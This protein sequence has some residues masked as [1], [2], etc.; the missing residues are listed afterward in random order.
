MY[1]YVHF[2]LLYEWAGGASSTIVAQGTIMC[3]NSLEEGTE[4]YS[5]IY[6]GSSKTREKIRG[7]T[8]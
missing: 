2:V 4:I 6:T 1:I 7:Y 5:G 8:K 3:V